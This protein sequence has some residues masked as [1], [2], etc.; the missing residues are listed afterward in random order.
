MS[1]EKY[2]SIMWLSITVLSSSTVH[3][4]ITFQNG[5]I[6]TTHYN[7]N[8]INQYDASGNFKGSIQV[9]GLNGA[10]LR[11]LG[12]KNG[13]MYAAID[14]GWGNDLSAVAFNS[15]GDIVEEYR[16]TGWIS[17]NISYGK[18]SFDNNDG[19]YVGQ[20]NGLMHFDIGSTYSG[21][22]K[23]DNGV[24][25]VKTLSSGNVLVATSYDVHE[26]DSDGNIVR[27]IQESDPNN[28]AP[29]DP[30]S[31]RFVDIRGIEYDES[32][33]K[34]FVSMLGSSASNI[35]L[36]EFDGSTGFLENAE[37]YWYGDD[38]VLL[39]DG[40]LLVGS[41][42]QAPGF[43]TGDLGYRGQFGSD[44]Q[45]F[46]TQISSVPVPTAAWLFGTALLSLISFKRKVS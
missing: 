26:L 37:S 27:T 46:V 14:G 39:D 10:E 21:E 3:S 42:T 12:Y 35:T 38:M 15:S 16:S 13:L 4:A 41:R 29:M 31:L 7:D 24:F 28:V 40:N 32:T 22:R 23:F 9:S 44:E 20:G 18:I 43:F 45:M 19:F 1:M 33:D 11:G 30:F 34:L 5:D 8:R 2:L 17:G 36:M 6:Y 25:D